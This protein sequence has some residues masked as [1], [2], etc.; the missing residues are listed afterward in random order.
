MN[1]ALANCKVTRRKES[2]SKAS[3]P[4]THQQLSFLTLA[5]SETLVLATIISS[6]SFTMLPSF[7]CKVR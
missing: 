5:M 6:V 2:A 3:F 4:F 1:K 7:R